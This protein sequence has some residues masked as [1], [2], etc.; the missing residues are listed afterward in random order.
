MGDRLELLKQLEE[1]GHDIEELD[2]QLAEE[3]VLLEKANQEVMDLKI[4]L[5]V[6]EKAK[7]DGEGKGT[8]TL[9]EIE[10]YRAEDEKLKADEERCEKNTS[11]FRQKIDNAD[12]II[13]QNVKQAEEK[14]NTLE[15]QNRILQN[16]RAEYGGIIQ[17]IDALKRMEEHFEGYQQSVRFVMREYAEGNLDFKGEV[18]GPVSKLISV[19]EKYHTAIETAL[20]A[21]LQ[22]IVVESEETAKSAIFIL[23]RAG[24]GRATFYPLS[25]IHPS[26]LSD[27]IRQ[28]KDLKGY[29]GRGDELISFNE[30]YRRVMEWLLQRTLVF[31]TLDN[32][33][34]AAKRLR[35]Q[36]K[37]VTLDGQQ[38]NAGGSFTGGSLRRDSG[39]LSRNSEIAQL[40]EQAGKLEQSIAV[41]QKETETTEEEIR[42]LGKQTK[43]AEQARDLLY[44]MS[45]AQFAELD[46]AKA[47]REANSSLL[48]KLTEDYE[49]FLSGADR[50]AKEIEKISSD[51]KEALHS[52]EM[53][54]A[55]RF[56]LD[57]EKQKRI[58]AKEEINAKIGD[59]RVAIG[60]TEKEAENVTEAVLGMDEQKRLTAEEKSQISVKL[61]QYA[62]KIKSL[63]AEKERDK[64]NAS[65]LKEE[66]TVLQSQ[67]TT[68]EEDSDDFDKEE[69]QLKEKIRS[70]NEDK[71]R[72]FAEYTR[73]ETRLNRLK[74]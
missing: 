26:G 69:N 6:C 11:S 57:E 20:G 8:V 70:A 15:E 43:D 73:S 34:E 66:L 65:R 18:Y 14:Q 71:E 17:K 32:A 24:A 49:N 46:T 63:E 59:I 27:E 68:A 19:K 25:S 58:E 45:R 16:Y 50:Y 47:K 10:K 35:Y 1:A 52:V 67:R 55:K 9:T 38:I 72:S 29:L 74:E 22:N 2:K 33:T 64:E 23:K 42:I 41:K 7:A 36:V 53:I 37:I 40:E 31:D 30:K 39:I 28:A 5:D 21:G 44:T 60:I 54:K 51:L 4:R 56:K 48:A 13:Q 61:E 3:L 62:E 12:A